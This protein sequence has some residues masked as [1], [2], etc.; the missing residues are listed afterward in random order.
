MEDSIKKLQ[1]IDA[2]FTADV[3]KYKQEYNA[4]IKKILADI[5]KRKLDS[6]RSALKI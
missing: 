2:K 6:V 3:E 4:V 5:E 1:E